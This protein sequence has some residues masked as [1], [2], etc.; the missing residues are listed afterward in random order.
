M[1][2]L[3]KRGA[4]VTIHIRA[5][6]AAVA[7]R[8]DVVELAQV[9]AFDQQPGRLGFVGEHGDKLDGELAPGGL[10]RLPHLARIDIGAG[11][12]FLAEHILAR[13]KRRHA[14]RHVVVVV[15]A[16]IHRL[17]VVAGQQLAEV[18]VDVGHAIEAAHPLSLRRVDIRNRHHF[19]VRN[20]FVIVEVVL[21]DLP[22]ADHADAHPFLACHVTNP[23]LVVVRKKSIVLPKYA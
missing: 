16:H 15:H 8:T 2:F 20:L 9:A 17:D 10:R 18:G 11:H 19:G 22:D 13:F 23:L 7:V 21:A 12:R 5:A 3:H 4:A 1:L 6:A 14:D